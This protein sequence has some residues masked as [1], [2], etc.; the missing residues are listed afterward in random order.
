MVYGDMRNIITPVA[1]YQIN[2]V[3]IE[4]Q[5][6]TILLALAPPGNFRGEG[7]SSKR[8]LVRGSPRG[9]SEGPSPRTPENFSANL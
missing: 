5:Y 8:G 6:K 4:Q 1:S 2:E 7:R 3:S 9:G